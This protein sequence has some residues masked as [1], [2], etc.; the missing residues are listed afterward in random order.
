MLASP[1]RTESNARRSPSS[2]FRGRGMIAISPRRGQKRNGPSSD[3]PFSDGST[4][5]QNV[6]FPPN[7]GKTTLLKIEPNV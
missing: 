7:R 5:N 4:R 3:G 1:K 6:L 2:P